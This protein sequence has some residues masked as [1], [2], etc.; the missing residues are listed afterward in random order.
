MARLR[1]NISNVCNFSCKHCH[2]FKITDNKLPKTLMSFGTMDYSIKTFIELM[3]KHGN[4][5]LTI[6]IYGGEPLINKKNL[7]EII[8]KYRSNYSG[9]SISWV[10]NTNG[11]LLTE[12]DAWFFKEHN[13]D[14][15]IS[16]DGGEQTHDKTKIDKLGKGTFSRVK[17]ALELV[18]KYDLVAQLNSYV[19]PENLDHLKEI[20]DVAK[21]YNISRIY[22]DLFYSK[23][24]TSA[25]E[26][27]KKYLEVFAYGADNDVKIFGPWDKVSENGSNDYLSELPTSIDVNV[28][29]SFFFNAFPMT[30]KMKFDIKN[31]KS[32]VESEEYPNFIHSVKNYFKKKCGDCSISSLCH[33]EAIRQF[34]YHVIE[35]EGYERSCN[36]MKLIIPAFNK[37]DFYEC[38]EKIPKDE[39]ENELFQV[40]ITYNC[41]KN[42]NFFAMPIV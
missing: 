11:S 26:V 10:V 2:V 27:F 8:K 34:Q 21:K 35:E 38:V 19:M 28:D 18:K 24:M 30:K 23:N 32:I 9:V 39:S 6:S 25:E 13:V 15:H 17:K 5:N 42:C 36:F 12:E 3:K 37:K 40:A 22:L 20:V 41:N 14:I 4:K 16:C 7:F 33:G 31:L 29:G 1:L